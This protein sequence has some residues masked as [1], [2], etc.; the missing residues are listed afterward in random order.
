MSIPIIKALLLTSWTGWMP[1]IPE[2]GSLTTGV[3]R[4]AVAK[5]QEALREQ[6]KAGLV[7]CHPQ[8]V[9]ELLPLFEDH[10]GPHDFYL[11]QF[12][13]ENFLFFVL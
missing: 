13:V 2:A 5:L 4:K 7:S 3:C 1:G 6:C 9:Q 11:L 10:K 12:S 8:G